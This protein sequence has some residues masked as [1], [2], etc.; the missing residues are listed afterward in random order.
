[1]LFNTIF[2]LGGFN[3]IV[4]ISRFI[5][6]HNFVN[7][8]IPS[9]HYVFVDVTVLF[10]YYTDVITPMGNDPEMSSKANDTKTKKRHFYQ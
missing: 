4:F 9:F 1:M 8:F 7:L 6:S 10:F 3:L 2:S 5:F